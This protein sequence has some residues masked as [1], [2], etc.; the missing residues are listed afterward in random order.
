[1]YVRVYHNK[2]KNIAHLFRGS[3]LSYLCI[4]EVPQVRREALVS[5]VSI[6][7]QHIRSQVKILDGKRSTWN[8]WICTFLLYT[9][10]GQSYHP[11]R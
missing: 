6:L 2:Q 9:A 4:N 8:D 11:Q 5:E 10:G 1:M 7:S 3:L